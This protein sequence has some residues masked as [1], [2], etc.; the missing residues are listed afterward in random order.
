MIR[1]PRLIFHA[2]AFLAAT[3]EGGTAIGQYQRLELLE[4]KDTGSMHHRDIKRPEM[5][6]ARLS[7]PAI[8]SN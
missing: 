2:I 7:T 6:I 8:F 1:Q 4:V 3:G 5:E